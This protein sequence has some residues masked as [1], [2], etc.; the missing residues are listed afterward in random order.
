MIRVQVVPTERRVGQ[1]F[2]SDPRREDPAF[3]ARCPSRARWSILTTHDELN[4][5]C[6][7]A[8]VCAEVHDGRVTVRFE[9]S[10][11]PAGGTKENQHAVSRVA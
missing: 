11:E 10:V 9:A 2:L 5:P 4:Q 1:D 8:K 7:V 6:P 3:S